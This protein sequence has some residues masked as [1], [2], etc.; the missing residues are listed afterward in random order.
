M[1]IASFIRDVSDFPKAGILF[2][3]ISP[4]LASPEAFGYVIEQFAEHIG[5]WD[6]IVGLDARGFIFGA[7]L[8]LRTRNSFVML[9]KPGKLPG[10]TMQQSYGLEYGTNTLAIQKDALKSWQ[11]VVLIDD[12]LATWGTMQAATK[13]VESSGTQVKKILF[14]M[15]LDALSGR[16]K[17]SWY[18]VFSLLHF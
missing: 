17:L 12:V 9:R 11:K 6:T 8:A 18:P 16:E 2:K 1:D 14:L 3:D 4:L 15:E 5:E 7:A 10:D 13:L